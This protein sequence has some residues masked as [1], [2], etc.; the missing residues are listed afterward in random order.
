MGPGAAILQT[1]DLKGCLKGVGDADD[2]TEINDLKETHIKT[3]AKR[4]M[5]E[6][7]SALAK[8]PPKKRGAP[9]PGAA[10]FSSAAGQHEQQRTPKGLHFEVPERC[11]FGSVAAECAGLQ[12]AD[13]SALAH[14]VSCDLPRCDAVAH[15]EQDVCLSSGGMASSEALHG[16][17][18]ATPPSQRW[19]ALPLGASLIGHGC[20]HAICTVLISRVP[21]MGHFRSRLHRFLVGAISEHEQ[22]RQT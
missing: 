12:L 20:G 16:L 7:R 10:S 4:L 21:P 9:E 22:S 17:G 8:A 6:T 15:N 11:Q 13:G 2:E 5:A 3:A 14:E 1:A 19:P 18:V